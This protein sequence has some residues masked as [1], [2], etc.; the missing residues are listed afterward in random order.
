MAA[1]GHC[2]EWESS[3]E[4]N[5]RCSFCLCP[6]LRLPRSVS[7][8]LSP[9]SLSRSF[10]LV[11]CLGCTNT[12]LLLLTSLPDRLIAD[13]RPWYPSNTAATQ[14]DT[15]GHLWLDQDQTK[16]LSLCGRTGF[17]WWWFQPE[18]F[19]YFCFSSSFPFCP[20]NTA[21]PTQLWTRQTINAWISDTYTQHKPTT[22]NFCLMLH[23]FQEDWM[24]GLEKYAE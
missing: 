8:S 13:A 2:G 21:A 10:L 3:G 16:A 15:F 11:S 7:R 14:H 20:P 1:R 9:L 19:C 4:K 18:I 24:D 12:L 5:R 6:S 23:W 17:I 22:A